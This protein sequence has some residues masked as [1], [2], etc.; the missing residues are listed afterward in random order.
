M[1]RSKYMYD[2][3]EILLARPHVEGTNKVSKTHDSVK[4]QVSLSFRKTN[5]KESLHG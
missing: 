5:E 4:T 3:Y 2:K 1:V